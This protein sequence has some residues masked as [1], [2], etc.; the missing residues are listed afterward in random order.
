MCLDLHDL[1]C[2]E[3]CNPLISRKNPANYKLHQKFPQNFNFH[4]NAK[5]RAI[6]RQKPP[7]TRTIN[8]S[9]KNSNEKKNFAIISVKLSHK[10]SSNPIHF[11]P[12]KNVFIF[13]FLLLF[14]PKNNFHHTLQHIINAL[15][16]IHLNLKQT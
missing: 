6:S 5:N 12:L 9:Q 16:N 1:F 13:T 7:P 15:K 10:L 8:H 3:K 14:L 2:I 4:S 11:I